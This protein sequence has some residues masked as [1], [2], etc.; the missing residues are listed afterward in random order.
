MNGVPFHPLL[1]HFPMVLATM[2]PLFAGY[3]LIRIHYGARPMRAWA[4]PVA[5]CAVLALSAFISVRTG[6]NE[7]DRV[8]DVVGEDVLHAHEEAGERLLILSAALFVIMIAG[9]FANY[10]AKLV[11]GGAAVATLFLL[12][13]AIQVGRAGGELVYL[14]GAAGVYQTAPTPHVDAP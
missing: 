9:L 7:E 1:V 10:P 11:R 5:V 14:H 8:E 4:V 13:A 3:A 12:I 2:L 6:E